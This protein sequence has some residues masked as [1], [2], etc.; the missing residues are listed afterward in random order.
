VVC[1]GLKQQIELSIRNLEKVSTVLHRQFCAPKAVSVIPAL[2]LALAIVEHRKQQ[3]H[4]KIGVR[5][6][7]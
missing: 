6:F 1:A 7:R 5:R 3:D 2:V 4:L